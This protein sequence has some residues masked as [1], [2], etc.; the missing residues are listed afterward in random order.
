MQKTKSVSGN[1]RPAAELIRK[2]W[3]LFTIVCVAGILRLWNLGWELPRLYE[4]AYPFHTAWGFW[5][6]QGSGFDFNPHFFNYPALTYYFQ[7]LTQ[8]LHYLVGSV[9]GEFPSI[10]AFSQHFDADPSI[11]ILVGR[12]VG[13]LMDTGSV[14]LS[15]KLTERWAGKTYGWLVGLLIAVN[16]THISQSHLISVDTSLTFFVLL[17]VYCFFRFLESDKTAWAVLGGLSVGFGASA[18]Y[19]GALLILP[20]AASFMFR[21]T[22]LANAIKS[23]FDKRFGIGLLVASVTFL[24][25]NPYVLLDFNAFYAAFTFEQFHAETGHL[26]LASSQSTISYYFTEVLPASIGWIPA[27]LLIVAGVGLLL[28]QSRTTHFLLVFPVLYIAVISFWQM[29]AERYFLPALPF[30]LMMAVGGLAEIWTWMTRMNAFR[31][32][33][34]G[35]LAAVAAFIL[36]GH[37]SLLAS[38][39]YHMS[40]SRPDTRTLAREWMDDSLAVGSSVAFAPLG[41]DI[42]ASKFVTLPLPYHPV[43]PGVTLPF[44]DLHWYQ[45]VDVIIESSFDYSRYMTDPVTY[46]TFIEFYD[47]LRSTGKVL[48]EFK[49]FDGQNGPSIAFIRPRTGEANEPLP[50]KLISALTN[51]Q[52]KELVSS[53]AGK[54]GLVC[55]RQGLILRSRQLL[56]LSLMGDSD[57]TAAQKTL[58]KTLMQLEEYDEAQ[59]VA[60]R[61]LQRHSDDARF[62][63]EMGELFIQKFEFDRAEAFLLRSQS[64]DPAIESNYLDLSMVYA[65]QNNVQKVA[66]VLEQC[67]KI[68]PA[69]SQKA[70][71]IRNRIA[72]LKNR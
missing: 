37:A 61:Y 63:S 62:G 3:P 52:N 16:P 59:R 15:F 47:S 57:N 22:T 64:V 33:K 69:G 7:F 72:A 1:N 8:A 5:N 39:R 54:L 70:A 6:F 29:R 32:L 18:K 12:I 44:Y 48:K 20:F 23:L 66:T 67:L 56:E 31:F 2:N 51:L 43:F 53:F 40:F 41:I 68:V 46:R 71:L 36:F 30:L 35:F 21:Q 60:N 49:P 9:T 10:Q 25:L 27:V 50:E 19:T 42:D 58:A 26:G 45:G 24:L 55:H 65:S 11:H 38:F 14:L 4:E 28:Q 13:A 17:A 34:S